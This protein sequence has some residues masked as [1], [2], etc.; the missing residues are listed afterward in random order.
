MRIGCFEHMILNHIAETLILNEQIVPSE[1]CFRE[2]SGKSCG[3]NI[4]KDVE[5][6]Q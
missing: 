3:L 1:T 4:L 2:Y 6:Q 5:K